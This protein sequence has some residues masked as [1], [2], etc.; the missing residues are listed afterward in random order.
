MIKCMEYETKQLRMIKSIENEITYANAEAS[1][2]KFEVLRASEVIQI[3]EEVQL[4]EDGQ[5]LAAH[6]KGAGPTSMP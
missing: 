5:E 1:A 2:A 6:N 3:L 4:P